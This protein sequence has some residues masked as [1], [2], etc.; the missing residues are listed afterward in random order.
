MSKV[1]QELPTKELLLGNEAIA[2][3]CLEAGVRFAAAY[4]G[5]PSSE[6]LQTIIAN[7]S[8][9]GVVTEWSNNEMV[10]FEKAMGYSLCGMRAM[11]SMKH[12]G[13]NW[14]ADP[15][16]VAIMG[17]VRAGVVIITA[18]DPHCHSSANE[19]DNRFYG[20]FFE[21]LVL[22][23]CSPAEAKEMA[24][25]AFAISEEIEL[26]VILRTVT[27]VSH[28]RSGVET[29]I[30]DDVAVHKGEFVPDKDRFWISGAKSL[31][32]HRLLHQQHK[33]LEAASENSEFNQYEPTE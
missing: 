9:Y 24:R 1:E 15:L 12:A 2:A 17:G 7:S 18:D 11:V 27:R 5:T 19:Q 26:P 30:H 21:T 28:A 16:S 20:L 29:S 23:P 25:K 14:V 22:E 13:L 3:G 33:L 32:R 31:V 8:K 4:P 6:I 10:A